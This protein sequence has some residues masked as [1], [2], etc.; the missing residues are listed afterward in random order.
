MKRIELHPLAV[1]DIEALAEYGA[2]Q[3]G[4][5]Q[6]A[7]YHDELVRQFQLLSENPQIGRQ[8]VAEQLD[9]HRF[10]FGS[11]IIFYTVDA[12][13]IVIRRV[14]HGHLNMLRHL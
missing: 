10:A 5:E 9:M 7:L 13:S 8:V 3:F 11:H 14:L 6:A 12:G 1:A 2:L 4:V